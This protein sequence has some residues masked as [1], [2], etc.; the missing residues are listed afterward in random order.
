[1]G[2]VLDSDLL[3]NTTPITGYLW[4]KAKSICA[5][6]KPS[7]I[8]GNKMLINAEFVMRTQHYIT[9]VIKEQL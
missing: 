3:C 1:M 6:G 7:R 4:G 5:A 8:M 2:C 9:L